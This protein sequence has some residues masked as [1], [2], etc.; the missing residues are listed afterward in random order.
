MPATTLKQLT[1][2]LLLLLLS[3]G[4]GNSANDEP[5][6]HTQ[7]HTHTHNPHNWQI[8]H[9]DFNV[10]VVVVGIAGSIVHIATTAPTCR[11]AG[12]QHHQ[13]HHHIR[14]A[15][16]LTENMAHNFK[17]MDTNHS[18]HSLP[19]YPSQHLNLNLAEAFRCVAA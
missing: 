13:H 8:T 19:I 14:R 1:L 6:V 11:S 3:A 4:N 5:N 9:I 10:C 12:G 2:L 18:T 7:T 17:A 16:M 15:K